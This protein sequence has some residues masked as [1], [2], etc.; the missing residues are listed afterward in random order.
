[1]Q[2]KIVDFVSM[3]NLLSFSVSD[4]NVVFSLLNGEAFDYIGSSRL[5][6]D[7]KEGNFNA[8]GGVNL[9]L[10]DIKCV[11]EFGQLNK[12]NL[13]L[14]SNNGKNNKLISQLA[15]ALNATSLEDSVPPASIQSF[16]EERPNL[17]A[18][19]IADHGREFKNKYYNGIL[20]DAESLDFDR[21]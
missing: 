19:L 3:F 11:I 12:G 16:L 7:L 1:M 10:D 14:H 21:Y 2:S 5:I 15:K 4:T 6:Y 13:Y 8:L 20:D 18:V 9:K 17:T